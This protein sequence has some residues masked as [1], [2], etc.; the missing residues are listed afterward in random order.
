MQMAPLS[1]TKVVSS[2]KA[3]HSALASISNE[4]FAPRP[5]WASIRAILALAALE[6]LELESIDISSAYLNGELKEEVYM[7]QPQ[8]FKEKTPDWVWRLRK[9]L[10]GLS[11][12][13]DAGMRSSMRCL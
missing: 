10:Y 2:P 9:A 3:T 8:G 7:H 12:L 5:K 13:V 11:R 4:A 1:D 6:D